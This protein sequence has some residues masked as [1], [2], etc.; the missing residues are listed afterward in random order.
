[1]NVD[2]NKLLQV[3]IFAGLNNEAVA[4]IH[5]YGA[6]EPAPEFVLKSVEDTEDATVI[7]A[8]DE[9]NDSI[10]FALFNEG[11]SLFGNVYK[12]ILN[13]EGDYVLSLKEYELSTGNV[14]REVFQEVEGGIAFLC[15]ELNGEQ[16]FQWHPSRIEQIVED[17]E[18]E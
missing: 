8:Q 12:I 3:P 11:K 6:W 15:L 5:E 4:Y 1:M 16:I 18:V 9:M 14:I 7:Y 13:E 17:Q 2:L 10:M